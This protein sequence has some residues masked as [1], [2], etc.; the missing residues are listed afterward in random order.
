MVGVGKKSAKTTECLRYLW[1]HWPD[2][3]LLQNHKRGQRLTPNAHGHSRQTGT[4]VPGCF[5]SEVK[6][7]I[8]EKLVTASGKFE[9]M[10][11]LLYTFSPVRGREQLG[12]QSM[13]RIPSPTHPFAGIFVQCTVWTA[14]YGLVMVS[15][16]WLKSQPLEAAFQHWASVLFPL[17]QGTDTKHNNRLGTRL[18]A[19]WIDAHLGCAPGT[20]LLCHFQTIWAS[21]V[22]GLL[23]TFQPQP[24]LWSTWACGHIQT[25]PD[26]QSVHFSLPVLQIL[27]WLWGERCH[28]TPDS[29]PRNRSPQQWGGT[30]ALGPGF[31]SEGP[32]WRPGCY[33]STELFLVFYLPQKIKKVLMVELKCSHSFIPLQNT[34][35]VPV[36]SANKPSQAGS[37]QK[38]QEM[39]RALLLPVES[40]LQGQGRPGLESG[41]PQT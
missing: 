18:N 17:F 39:W 15:L 35:H 6:N 5:H 38:M 23:A 29:Q 26:R 11:L 27:C 10:P 37:E 22:S 20:P 28:S 2:L 33:F 12:E 9:K 1:A 21:P 19:W 3:R 16:D 25:I 40:P 34:H 4:W 24:P 8:P 30:Q 36:L 7:S 31:L 14:E 41:F 32:R 13:S